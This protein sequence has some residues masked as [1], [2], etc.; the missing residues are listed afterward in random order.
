MILNNWV[1]P[2]GPAG[3]L[4]TAFPGAGDQINIAVTVRATHTAMS[5]AQ[6]GPMSTALAVT[7]L[8]S[9]QGPGDQITWSSGATATA[10]VASGGWSGQVGRQGNRSGPASGSPYRLTCSGPGGAATVVV[11]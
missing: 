4:R 6:T 8:A 5:L 9:P 3:I 11:P 7:R 10:C 2:G 1:G